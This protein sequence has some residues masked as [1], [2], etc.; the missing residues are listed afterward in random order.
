MANQV[1]YNALKPRPFRCCPNLDNLTSELNPN[2]VNASV[3]IVELKHT[4]LDS[5]L[6][7]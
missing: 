6:L 5:S 2:E 3:A 7:S 1:Y 4:E